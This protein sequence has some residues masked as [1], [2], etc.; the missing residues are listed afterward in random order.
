MT[1][2]LFNAKPLAEPMLTYHQY[3]PYKQTSLKYDFY[4]KYNFQ[5]KLD[6]L[7]IKHISE[8]CLQNGDHFEQVPMCQ[9]TDSKNNRSLCNPIET[10]NNRDHPLYVPSQ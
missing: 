1:C 2:H 5:P 4:S 3:D 6:F 8:C 10:T 7:S 9:R